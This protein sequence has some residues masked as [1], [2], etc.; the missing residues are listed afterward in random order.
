MRA[1]TSK[2]WLPDTTTSARDHGTSTTI[3]RPV[4]SDLIA[5]RPQKNP[6][7]QGPLGTASPTVPQKNPCGQIVH[8]S[9]ERRPV[10]LFKVPRG[11]GY[12]WRVSVDS[13]Q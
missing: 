10:M 3:D 9:A 1:V 5:P 2:Q 8:S 7:A 4:G 13:K 11:Q 12:W 6:S